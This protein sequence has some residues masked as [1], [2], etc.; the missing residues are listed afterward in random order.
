MGDKVGVVWKVIKDLT[1][2]RRTEAWRETNGPKKTNLT[3]EDRL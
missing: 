2:H 3:E 1:E